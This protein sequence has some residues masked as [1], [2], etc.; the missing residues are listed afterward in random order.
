MHLL[1]IL[2]TIKW[3]TW[4]LH[5]LSIIEEVLLQEYPTSFLFSKLKGEMDSFAYAENVT[6]IL[7]K[8]INQL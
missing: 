5:W 8:K 6:I 7:L 3:D 1:F 4:I 2:P